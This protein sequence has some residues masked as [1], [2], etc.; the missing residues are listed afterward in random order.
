MISNERQYQTTRGQAAKFR[1]ALE[2]KPVEGLHPKLLK[3]MREGAESQL[4]EIEEQLKDYEVLRAGRV[5]SFKANSIKGIGEALV[6]ARI[7]RNLTHKAL[8][9]QMNLA[10]Q[11]IQR[12]E[13]TRYA[14][15]SM[16]RLQAVAPRVTLAFRWS[17]CRRS[18]TPSGCASTRCLLWNSLTMAK[19]S[20]KLVIE[21]HTTL[22]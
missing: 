12:Y 16:E 9:Q 20:R 3:G 13:A 15:V 5:V 2:A 17:D 6:K 10:E 21:F 14:G 7:I 1:K 11:Q 8:A 4:A 18:L 19:S 22:P